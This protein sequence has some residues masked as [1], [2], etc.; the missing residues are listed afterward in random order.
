M[1]TSFVLLIECTNLRCFDLALLKE[2]EA[3]A[4]RERVSPVYLARI[5]VGLGEKE[6]ALSWLRK[7]YDEHS[8]HVL[9]LRI[10][11]TYDP[12]RADPRFTELLRGVG[13]SP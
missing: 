7:S 12:L 8:D 9:S 3:R 13:L 4:L 5:Y 11:P 10:E 6:Q 2:L 1:I